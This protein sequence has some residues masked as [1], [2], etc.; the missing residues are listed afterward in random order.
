MNPLFSM[1]GSRNGIGDVIRLYR[2]AKQN[3]S[4]LGELLYQNGR[5]DQSQMEAMKGMNPAQMGDYLRQNGVL[6][7]S[8]LQKGNQFA[9]PVKQSVS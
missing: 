2:Q 4:M 5:I 7:Q 3:P 6:S 1:M 8:F 9:N